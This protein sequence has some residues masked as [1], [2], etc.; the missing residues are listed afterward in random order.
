MKDNQFDVTDKV[1][2]EIQQQPEVEM[3]V[4]KHNDYI[5]AQTL[6]VS[7][8]LVDAVK[9]NNTNF[10]QLDDNIQTNIKVTKL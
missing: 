1:E 8:K 5:S 2:I 7:I 4:N 3:A 9:E 6:S 10:V